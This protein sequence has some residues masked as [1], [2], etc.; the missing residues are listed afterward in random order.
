MRPL[1]TDMYRFRQIL[2]CLFHFRD[3]KSD[4]VI[5]E[6]NLGGT[7]P[8]FVCDAEVLQVY[9][10]MV[11]PESSR[12]TAC[13]QDLGAIKSTDSMSLDR[14]T[15]NATE[16]LPY[17]GHRC[18]ANKILPLIWNRFDVLELPYQEIFVIV[19]ED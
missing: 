4:P 19:H 14:E 6:L 2:P 15:G 13:G 16:L 10:R 7:A 3:W 12:S 1:L 17:L 9:G 11:L 8:Q 5:P 18:V